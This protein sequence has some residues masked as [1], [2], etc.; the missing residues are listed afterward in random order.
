MNV[1]TGDIFNEMTV[2]KTCF[3]TVFHLT[4]TTFNDI[5]SIQWFRYVPVL[6]C[7]RE[8]SWLNSEC[9]NITI[10][11][12]YHW[13]FEGTIEIHV[14]CKT[15]DERN[16]GLC[17]CVCVCICVGCWSTNLF[18]IIDDDWLKTVR[19][20]SYSNTSCGYKPCGTSSPGHNWSHCLSYWLSFRLIAI[21]I[22]R[23]TKHLH[24]WTIFIHQ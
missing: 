9:Y 12:H 20:S 5:F 18:L 22:N 10:T 21:D 15:N 16:D 2:S 3:I 13:I 11:G 17:V 14:I 1:W 19:R 8:S 23:Q 24:R 4:F 6:K 7:K